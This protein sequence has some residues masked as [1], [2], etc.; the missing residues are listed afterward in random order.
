MLS[1]ID[2][3]RPWYDAVRPA[4]AR[5][6]LDVG[7]VA[8]ALNAAA[9]PLALVNQ[10]GLPLR[11]VP[12]DQ[13]PDGRAYEEFIGATGCVP[14]RENLH[15]FFNGLVWLTFPRIKQQLNALQAAQIALAGVG[16]SRGAARDGATIFDENSA[17][18]V[19]RAGGEGERLVAA[20]R[21][22][23]WIEALYERRDAFGPDAEVWLF[24]HALMEKLVAPRKAITAHTRVVVVGD[25]YFA[26]S[27]D[28]RRAW[29]DGRV[30]AELA[31]QGLSTACFTPLPVLGVPGWWE[32]QDHAFYADTTVFRPKR[33]V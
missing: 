9:A 10:R 8:E 15:D 4:F 29:I 19:V 11:F 31:D 30:A 7:S 24:G 12:Q 21:A 3:A 14:T 1:Q 18:L 13:L 6:G 5:L 32:G 33:A 27:H 22:H 20:L 17:L 25:E 23:G 28:Q 16:K 26:L 2:W